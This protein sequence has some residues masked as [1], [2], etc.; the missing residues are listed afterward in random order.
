[1]VPTGDPSEPEGGSGISLLRT[2]G[3]PVRRV[4]GDGRPTAG[5]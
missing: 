1:M 2:P 3:L 4:P 5:G